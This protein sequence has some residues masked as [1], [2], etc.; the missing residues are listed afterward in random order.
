M[1]SNHHQSPFILI[2]DEPQFLVVNKIKPL[3]F[4]NQQQ[5]LGLFNHVKHHLQRDQLYPVHRLDKLTTGLIIFAKTQSA[6]SA[7]YRLF[8]ERHIEKYYIALAAG[9]PK[10]KQGWVKGDMIKSRRGSYK[11]T[12]SMDNPAITQFTSAAIE[13]QQ[14]IFLIKL[15]TGK[16]H[17]IRVA[18]KSVAAP[19]LGD[20]IYN[21]ASASQQE[22]MYLHS[23]VLRFTFNQQQ[24][25]YY[26]D[27]IDGVW[28]NQP[29]C[30]Q[31]LK[32]W[33]SPWQQF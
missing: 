27:T 32:D 1:A 3:D 33:L 31:Q 9:R 18:L 13:A 16:T 4:H 24:Y 11:L 25:T 23:W 22:R 10:K 20:P 28:F 8:V 26:A 14:R 2:A 12:R 7:F 21:G 15:H 30:Q 17:Q 5:Q 19:I 29:Q 6:A